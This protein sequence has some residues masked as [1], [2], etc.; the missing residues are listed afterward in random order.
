MNCKFPST[1]TF[2]LRD[3]GRQVDSNIHLNKIV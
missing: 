3:M 2:E 1:V